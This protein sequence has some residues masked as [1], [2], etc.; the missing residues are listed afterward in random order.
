MD[1]TGITLANVL[2]PSRVPRKLWK[3]TRSPT[4]EVS[5]LEVQG[6]GRAPD[7]DMTAMV[8]ASVVADEVTENEP[9][10]KNRLRSSWS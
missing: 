10:S 8:V 9:M 1:L 5:D 4:Q 7:L 2:R 6:M 3:G